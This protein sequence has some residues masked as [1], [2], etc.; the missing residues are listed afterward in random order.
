MVGAA[1]WAL[2]LGWLSTRYDEVRPALFHLAVWVPLLAILWRLARRKVDLSWRLMGLGVVLFALGDASWD[3]I[4]ATGQ[5]PDASWADAVYLAGYAILAAGIVV[6]LRTHGGPDRRNGLID[7]VLLA[8]P[9][10]VLI[11]EFLVVPGDDSTQSLIVRVVTAAYPL[12][13]ALLVAGLVWL[14]VLPGLS[15]RVVVPLAI[16]MVATLVLDVLWAAGS[17]AGAEGLTRAVNGLY[18]LSYVVLAGGV[19]LGASLPLPKVPGDQSTAIPWGRVLLLGAGLVAAPLAG[20]LGVVF[21]QRLE[22]VLVVCATLVAAALVVLRF[23]RLVND[24]NQTTDELTTARNE[25][26]E[27]AVRDPL[28][29]VYNRLILPDHLAVLASGTGPPAAVLSLDLDH[30]KQVNDDHGHHAGDVVLETVAK[31]LRE[32][33]RS[34]DAIIRMGGD[35]FLVILWD[36]SATEATEL[37]TRIVAA[38]EEPIPYRN[39][40]LHVSASVGIALVG[41][42][43]SLTDTDEILHRADVAMY[44]AKRTGSGLVQMTVN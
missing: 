27:Q 21:H 10:V 38:T 24:L 26:R 25:I 33:T 32:S 11:T 42:G 30:F 9:T 18:P 1:S 5:Q 22:P 37:A 8:V 20:V 39:D 16:G 23:V 14:L 19:A 31:R 17:L 43:A 2:A 36:V 4:Q 6:L 41:T 3:V 15:R 7:G 44:Q 12:A 29:G 34:Q 28:T 40:H 13:D 35:E